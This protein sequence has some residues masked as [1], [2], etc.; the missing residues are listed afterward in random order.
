[1]DIAIY[2][3]RFV[4]LSL[5]F[6]IS[7]KLALSRNMWFINLRKTGIS[8]AGIVKQMGF[9]ETEATEYIIIIQGNL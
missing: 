2:T 7:Y 9:S 8:S 4:L 6:Q 1:M 5:S 3:G